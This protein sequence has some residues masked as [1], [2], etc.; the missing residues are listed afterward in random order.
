MIT[1]ILIVSIALIVYRFASRTYV[2]SSGDIEVE[3]PTRKQ[4]ERLFEIAKNL[5]R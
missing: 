5:K 1:H 3:A 2:I 4:A